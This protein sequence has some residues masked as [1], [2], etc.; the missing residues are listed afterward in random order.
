M[1]KHK[2]RPPS[3]ESE[4]PVWRAED[5]ARARPAS[6]VLPGIFSEERVQ[7][8]LK[9]RGRPR[10]QAPKVRVG[11]RLSPEVL[12]HFKAGGEGWQTRIDSALRQFIQLQTPH[13]RG[14]RRT[15][16]DGRPEQN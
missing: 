10:A 11:I 4:H 8:L 9:S 3:G 16:D 13:R 12:A 1:S 7:S 2:K 6:E 14:G 5:F 15:P